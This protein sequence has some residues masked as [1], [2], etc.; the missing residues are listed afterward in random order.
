[1]LQSHDDGGILGEFLPPR[2]GVGGREERQR[3]RGRAAQERVRRPDRAVD[4]VERLA[5]ETG[6]EG[7]E[8]DLLPALLARGRE[9]P[10][11]PEGLAI[12][13]LPAQEGQGRNRD[14]RI[15]VARQLAYLR[16]RFRSE[17]RVGV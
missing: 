8:R 4:E 17:R 14:V 11:T 1:H 5:A 9:G 10:E 16:C 3:F 12:L 2:R 13:D 6:H 7:L 15:R